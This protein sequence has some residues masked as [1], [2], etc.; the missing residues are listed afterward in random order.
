[1]KHIIRV[2]IIP[3][4]QCGN[5]V[6]RYRSTVKK[7]T[8]CNRVCDRAWR[9]VPVDAGNCIECGDAMT[10]QRG[11]PHPKRLCSIRCINQHYRI[12]AILKERGKA[13]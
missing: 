4:E 1:M 8:F 13:A 9:S 7:H 6:K 11:A 5:P 12:R 2:V 10:K 3:C